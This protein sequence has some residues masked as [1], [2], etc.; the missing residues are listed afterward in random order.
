[1]LNMIGFSR[2]SALTGEKREGK[3]LSFHLVSLPLFCHICFSLCALG[4][5][6]AGHLAWPQPDRQFEADHM[7]QAERNFSHPFF[8]FLSYYRGDL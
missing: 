2:S 3:L 6:T 4:G 7:E 5:S 8:L 1:M